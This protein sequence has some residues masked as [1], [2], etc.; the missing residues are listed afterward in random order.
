MFCNSCGASQK[1]ANQSNCS[2]CG[3]LYD[4]TTHKIEQSIQKLN[5]HGNK[6]KL[7][8]VAYEGENY[9]EALNYYNSCLEI[10]TDFFEAWYK[11]GLCLVK[12]STVG[13][14]KSNASLPCFKQAINN[15]PNTESFKKRFLIDIV[16]ILSSTIPEI[17][18]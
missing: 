13:N 3:A 6:F 9:D 14:L 7:A 5:E 16:P 4:N 1:N 2:F 12:T 10:D 18:T 15:S 11:K 8:E 17:F